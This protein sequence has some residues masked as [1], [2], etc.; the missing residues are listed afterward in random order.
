VDREEPTAA[1]GLTAIRG[2]AFSTVLTAR[3]A[4]RRTTI[5]PFMGGASQRTSGSGL[6]SN[7][8]AHYRA[9]PAFMIAGAGSNRCDACPMNRN[10]WLLVLGIAMAVLTVVPFF[11]FDMRLQH[12][13]GP[14]IIGL[15]FAATKARTAEILT[16]WGS[17]G[18]R[19]AHLSLIVDYAYL[20]S[21][22]GFFTLAGFATRDL[23][24]AR[25]WRR[26]AAAGA[27][28]P[29]FA[30]A[31]AIF[32]AIENVFLLLV[33]D[34]HGGGSAP[35]IATICSTIKFTLIAMAIGYVLC[36]LAWRL[37]QATAKLTSALM[38]Q[39]RSRAR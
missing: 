22:G 8:G 21:Y 34:G 24:R 27:I 35:L 17:T 25:A 5:R 6:P 10:Q 4:T 29:L 26:L 1:D 39:H 16:Q 33:L 32:D 31:A 3:E 30:A 18:R 37:R 2:S 14:G 15:E 12:T 11:L 7:A 9:M 20:L 36:G 28:L 13:G 23:A 19:L 38:R